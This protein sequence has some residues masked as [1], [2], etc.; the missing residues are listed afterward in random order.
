MNTQNKKILCNLDTFITISN[1][2]VKNMVPNLTRAL[3]GNV[4]ELCGQRHAR[5]DAAHLRGQE[6]RTII[7]KMFDAVKVDFG[8]TDGMVCVD[9]DLFTE[10]IREYHSNPDNFHW[11]CSDCHRLYDRPDSTITEDMFV[12]RNTSQSVQKSPMIDII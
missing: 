12:R 8:A 11:L 2:Y 6:R 10:K 9:L 1:D 7:C 3:K 5:L 4:C